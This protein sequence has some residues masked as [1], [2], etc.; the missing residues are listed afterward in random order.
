M[1]TLSRQLT[2]LGYYLVDLCWNR[3][4]LILR[5]TLF[6]TWIQNLSVKN[7]ETN[8]ITL[9]SNGF[10]VICVNGDSPR[11]FSDQYSGRAVC[12]VAWESIGDSRAQ[13]VNGLVGQTIHI[14]MNSRD[15]FFHSFTTEVNH[16]LY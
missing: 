9:V 15:S 1:V 8:L 7:S 3:Y 10:D 2:I 14:D 4:V 12:F 5:Y 11:T 13:R 16:D 6:A